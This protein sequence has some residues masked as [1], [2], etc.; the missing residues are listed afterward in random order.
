[1]ELVTRS[2]SMMDGNRRAQGAALEFCGFGPSECAP[3]VISTGPHWARWRL[4]E[5]AQA[6]ATSL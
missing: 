3:R 2:F 4:G 6:N 1:M 5:Y